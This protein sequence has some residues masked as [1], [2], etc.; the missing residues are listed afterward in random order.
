MPVRNAHL[1]QTMIK[2][3]LLGIITL[4]STLLSAQKYDHQWPFGYGTNIPLQFGISLLDFNGGQVSV[5]SFTENMAEIGSTRMPN[6]PLD[7][8]MLF[9]SDCTCQL[10]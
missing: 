5:A 7:Y 10:P 6:Y 9:L 8:K 2:N 4:L 3:Y 1:F